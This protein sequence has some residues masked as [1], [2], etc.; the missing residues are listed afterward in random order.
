V[1]L[2]NN[3][4]YGHSVLGNTLGISLV[5]G[6]LHPDPFADEGEHHFSYAM[7]PHAGD[8]VAGGVVNAAQ[9]FNAPMIVL[10]GSA[11]APATPL[12][13]IDGLEL[14]F[15][16]LKRAHDRD[17]L[18]LRVYEP[19]GSSGVSTLTFDRPVKSATFVNILEEDLQDEVEVDG[20]SVNLD[21]RPWE[22]VSLY[23][24]L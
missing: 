13:S 16:A 7:L 11:D 24:E 9:A 21:L 1:A 8:W 20:N 15:S 3:G 10:T 19:H 6:P 22:L 17:G 2:L 12:V 23:I 14:G 18:V 5:R 4:K